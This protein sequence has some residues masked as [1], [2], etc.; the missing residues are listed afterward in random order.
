MI[1]AYNL[2]GYNP[3]RDFSYIEI[4]REL[5]KLHPQ[6]VEDVISQIRQLGGKVSP[7]DKSGLLNINGEFTISLVIAR[8]QKI[9]SGIYRWNIR[10]DLVLRPDITV[11]VRM[12]ES[13]KRAFDYYLLPACDMELDFLRLAENNGIYLDVYRFDSLDYLFGMAE[14]AQIKEAV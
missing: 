12:D 9:P 14:R 1:R 8:C 5:R 3:D 2:V 11:V 7:D 4:N 6:I 13:N 10:L